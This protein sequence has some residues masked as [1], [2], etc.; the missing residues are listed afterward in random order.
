MIAFIP[1]QSR[2]VILVGFCALGF[3]PLGHGQLDG[4]SLLIDHLKSPDSHVRSEAAR[5]LG[6]S[7]DPRAVEP[8]I[9]TLE[10]TDFDAAYVAALALGNIGDP[11]AVKPLIAALKPRA[12]L[13]GQGISP[14]SAWLPDGAAYALGKIGTAAVLPLIAALSDSDSSVR[15]A[16]AHALGETKDPRAIA[17]ILAALR[18]P[19][20]DVRN[21]M[22]EALG[23]F[24]P[25]SVPPLI[26]ALKD[27]DSNVR[28][29]AASV[30]GGRLGIG[31]Y[32]PDAV[33][34]LLAAL[35]ERDMA[36]VAGAHEFFIDRG[37]AG[38]EDVLIEALGEFGDKDMAQD[39]LTCRNSKLEE[40]ASS[41]GLKH[42]YRIQEVRT[43]SSPLATWGHAHR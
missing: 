25:L 27:Q 40:A 37:E 1:R 10:D 42:D 31:S 41:W 14:K 29:A 35:A 7:K 16:A 28:R 23:F 13:P 17:P 15:T 36:V 21:S 18:E 9:A 8:L 34:A 5:A 6:K 20:D 39:F 3:T 12:S 32:Y 24:G 38:S 43:A 11:R 19:N 22:V 33:S 30:F 4:V 26:G 2:R